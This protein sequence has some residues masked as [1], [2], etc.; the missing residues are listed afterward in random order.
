MVKDNLVFVQ[1]ML[2]CIRKIET[3]AGSMSYEGFLQ[4]EWD[5][6]GV[7][8]NL[9]I[10]GE[11]ANKIDERFASENPEIPWKD[12]VGMRNKLVH[13]YFGLDLEKVWNTVQD[14]LPVLKEKL[15][16]LL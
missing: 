13:D 16:K 6:D 15:T 1:H 7:F 14:D 12:I 3:H 9:E 4:S 11:A 10:I 5:Q 8:R 2:D